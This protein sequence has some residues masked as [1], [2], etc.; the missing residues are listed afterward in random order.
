MWNISLPDFRTQFV[1]LLK[2]GIHTMYCVKWKMTILFLT[3]RFKIVI[4]IYFIFKDCSI[5]CIDIYIIYYFS[6]FF[7][8]NS[9]ITCY[10]CVQLIKF[11]YIFICICFVLNKVQCIIHHMNNS[12]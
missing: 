10:V 9:I 1:T 5:F 4:F 7:P 3:Y 12:T 6:I 11:I 2:S 8:L